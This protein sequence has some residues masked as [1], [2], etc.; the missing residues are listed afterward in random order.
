MRIGLFGVAGVLLLLSACGGDEEESAATSPPPTAAPTATSTGT[1]SLTAKP[2]ANVPADWLTFVSPDGL[3]S[4]RY[5]PGWFAEVT[6]TPPPDAGATIYQAGILYNTDPGTLGPTSPPGITKIDLEVGLPA[7]GDCRVAPPGA[8][9]TTLGGTTAW[10]VTNAS[11]N[12]FDLRAT[13]V[14]AY[15]EGRCFS[16]IAFFGVESHDEDVFR[17]I[18]GT[19][20]FN[21]AKS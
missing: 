3:F 4:L 7:T 14:K 13:T 5:P 10:T 1:V 8:T 11:V 2:T 18:V 19:F 15:F 17:Q 21:E 6:P 16:L 20:Q 12:D 9:G